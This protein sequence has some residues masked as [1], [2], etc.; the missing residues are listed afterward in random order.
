MGP[1]WWS[2]SWLAGGRWV[3]CS[4]VMAGVPLRWSDEGSGAGPGT[5]RARHR[6]QDRSV[7]PVVRIAEMQ[8]VD[9]EAAEPVGVL[10]DRA[11]TAVARA[12]LDLLGGGYGRRVL[13]L[14]GPGDRQGVV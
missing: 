3:V 14:A 9:A 11:G 8:A 7:L 5:R 12:T 13:G 1:R 6:W 10:I 4:S 2:V